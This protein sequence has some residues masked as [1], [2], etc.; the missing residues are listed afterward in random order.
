MSEPKNQRQKDAVRGE[1]N[2]TNSCQDCPK[3]P[4]INDESLCNKGLEK[5][6]TSD[7]KESD[8]LE[9][10]WWVN[11]PDHN[12]CFWTFIKDKSSPEGVMQELVQSDLANLFGWSTT[13]THFVLKQ[14]IE[15]L[16]TALKLQYPRDLLIED[17]GDISIDDS[18]NNFDSYDDDSFE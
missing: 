12:N 1:L 3:K 18:L 8:N 6:N 10:D 13:K 2:P 4:N 9:C 14:A 15:E 7:N 11:S 16:V 17:S 5:I